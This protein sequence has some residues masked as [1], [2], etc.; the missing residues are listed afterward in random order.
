MKKKIEERQKIL[1][2][3]ER[4]RK[5]QEEKRNSNTRFVAKQDGTNPAMI[6]K[7]KT[8]GKTVKVPLYAYQNVMDALID[9][10]G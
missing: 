7:D 5:A 6:I 10:F 3:E 9:L 1:D 2:E 8:T 4:V